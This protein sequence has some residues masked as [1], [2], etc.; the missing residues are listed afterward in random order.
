MGDRR[1]DRLEERTQLRLG[2]LALDGR[3]V[4][5]LKAP[6]AH[7]LARC[8]RCTVFE[9]GR[10]AD[11][12]HGGNPPSEKIAQRIVVEARV[13]QDST[14]GPALERWRAVCQPARPRA[15]TSCAPETTGA[16]GLT[17]RSETCDG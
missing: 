14:E 8:A 1:T 10:Y 6:T 5:V 12:A 4:S 16:R 3:G 15:R 2:F 7:R 9:A 17:Q 13:T 11:E